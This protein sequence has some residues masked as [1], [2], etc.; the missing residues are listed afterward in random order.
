MT[1]TVDANG[2]VS[3]ILLAAGLGTRLRPLTD[4]VPKCLVPIAGRPLLDYWFERLEEA[5]IR[6][7]LINTHHHP[8]QVE[9]YIA[10]VVARGRCSVVTVH[11]P[12]LLGSAGTVTANRDFARDDEDCL[13]IYADNLSDVDLGALLAVHRSHNDPITM[14]LFHA[15]QPEQ[16]GIAELDESG[17]IVG[18][19]EKPAHPVRDLANGG[20]YALS[21]S[22]FHEIADMR[23]F[24]LACDVMPAFIGR[25]RGWIWDS[26]HRDIGTHEA[27]R[28][29][30]LDARR[31]FGPS[32]GAGA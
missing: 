29:A 4:R 14:M 23:G 8:D 17:R 2:N 30:E 22:A 10:R 28:Q 18:F 1:S 27:L 16:C 32:V 11:E 26:Y 15:P 12:E 21:A 5:G 19:V 25:M 13:I 20:V 9:A 31:V 3:A 6:D 24:D 7:V